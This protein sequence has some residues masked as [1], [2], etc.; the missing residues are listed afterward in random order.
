MSNELLARLT[1]DEFADDIGFTLPPAP[2]RRVL[3][4]SPDVRRLSAALRY[5]QLT[6]QD[7][8]QF[9]GGLLKAY[10]QDEVFRYDLALAALAV[11]M[12]HWRNPF[13]EEYLIDLARIRRPELPIAPRI[14]RECLQARFAFPRTE[15]RTAR[16]SVS[17]RP[18]LNPF[19][20]TP[21]SWQGKHKIIGISW[22]TY[23]EARHA[24][25]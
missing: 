2:F 16:Y 7:V 18:P 13:A 23:A 17:A 14:A 9:V 22:S 6:I 4:R 15:I 20:L 12:E 11:A 5:R 10:R 1:T 3:Q 19:R 21:P 24:R 8:R 25:T